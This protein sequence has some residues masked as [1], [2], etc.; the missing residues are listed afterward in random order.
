V[1]IEIVELVGLNKLVT[2]RGWGYSNE[3]EKVEREAREEQI[4]C[5]MI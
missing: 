4:I 3:A 1:G 2:L 5:I